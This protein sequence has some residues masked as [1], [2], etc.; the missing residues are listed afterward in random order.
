MKDY[1]VFRNLISVCLS[2]YV[3]LQD[4]HTRLTPIKEATRTVT[5]LGPNEII[6]ENVVLIIG[7][8]ISPRNSYYGDYWSKHKPTLI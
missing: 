6:R 8:N 7:R 1:N 4:M 5:P 3:T 2:V